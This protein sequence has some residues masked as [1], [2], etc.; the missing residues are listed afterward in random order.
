MADPLEHATGLEKMEL[1]AKAAGNEVRWLPVFYFLVNFE[2]SYFF[3]MVP[4]IQ[5]LAFFLN[6]CYISTAASVLTPLSYFTL[7]VVK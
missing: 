2:I 3:S 1:K 6:L 4:Q 5:I 7:L